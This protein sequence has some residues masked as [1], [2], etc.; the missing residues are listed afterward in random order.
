MNDLLSKMKKSQEK[1]KKQNKQNLNILS[2]FNTLTDEEISIVLALR[3]KRLRLKKGFK[4]QEFSKNAQLSSPTTYSNF[5]QK[6]TISLINFIKV[7]REFG[8][9][10]EL[11]T[12]M[13]PKNIEELLEIGENKNI[14]KKRVRTNNEI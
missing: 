7:I 6:G 10:D 9:L 5:E 12:L 8:L 1:I 3:A 4:Q 14:I 13:K 2:D 11:E